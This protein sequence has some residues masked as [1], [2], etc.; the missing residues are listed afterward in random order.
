MNYEIR[1]VEESDLEDIQ[2]LNIESWLKTYSDIIPEKKMKKEIG[3]PRE[4][5]LE[6][7]ND[8]R[9]VFLVAEVQGKVVGTINFCW[10]EDN[11]HEFVD[12][13]ENEAQLRS[14]YLHPDYWNEGIGTKLFRRGL[15]RLPEDKKLLK[16]ESLAEND[17]GRGFYDK[18]GFE[19]VG[20]SEV[21]LFGDR[22]PTVIQQKDLV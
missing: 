15:E 1:E 8:D 4:R 9:L 7:K 3:Y 17:I 11:T 5:L 13:E 16:V 12:T 6:K 21:D 22:Y 14:V 18:L 20:H 10:S 2:E 19:V